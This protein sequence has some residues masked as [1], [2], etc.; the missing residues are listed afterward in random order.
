MKEEKER[1][2]ILMYQL[3]PRSFG[4][5]EEIRAIINCFTKN[6]EQIKSPNFNLSSDGVLKI[7]SEDLKS[8]NFRVEESK[9]V[10]HK[11][12]VPVLFWKNNALCFIECRRTNRCFPKCTRRHCT[13][14]KLCGLQTSTN[15]F[16]H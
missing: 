5:T 15:D 7:I 3:F 14:C 6:Y 9:S 11:I 16:L 10:E 8:I 12:K 13:H 1:K 4:I 2:Y